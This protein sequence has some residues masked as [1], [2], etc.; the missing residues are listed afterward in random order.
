[1]PSDDLL[2]RYAELVV[3]VAA[4]VQ[5]DQVLSVVCYLEQA[6]L[7][8]EVAAAAY[9]AGARYVDIGYAVQ[10]V[11]REMIRHAPADVL[12][13]TPPWELTR[14]EY[15][16]EQH[17]AFIAFTGEPHPELFADLDGERVGRAYP[18]ELA[19][20]SMEIIGERTI[21]TT[22]VGCPTPGWAEKM[23]GE[24]DV[25][26]LWELVARAVRL[27]EADP[28]AAWRS[29]N[30]RLRARAAALD[31]RRFDALRFRGPGTDLT[32]GL[33]PT[34]RWILSAKET[35]DGTPFI[36]NVPTEEVW[37]TPDPTRT[38]GTVRAT[39]PLAL[40]GLVIE[41]LELEFSAGRI[42]SARAA[43]AEEA[44]RA[45]VDT[46]DG[47]SRLGE[48]A[49]V[50]RTSRVGEL[51]ITFYDTLF[52]ENAAA[53]VALGACYRAAIADGRGGNDSA[54]H[55]DFMIGEVDVE[56][57]GLTADGSTVP[58]LRGNEW[59]LA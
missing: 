59:V 13:W 3:R 34:S 15:L 21:N 22:A 7:A 10:Y 32:I 54:T 18:R 40:S 17:G 5:P 43:T 49:L 45:H 29:H 26:R 1:M 11:R 44:L 35:V 48:V 24:A 41:R 8:R 58:I 2:R 36:G 37:T 27:D 56:V 23:F 19:L 55:T 12:E 25:D 4:N 28:V 38:E 9:E 51:D 53:H 6:S 20:R 14:L 31:E 39:R 46:D 30:E 57:D 47:A 16:H 42:S 50:D 52:D 33:L